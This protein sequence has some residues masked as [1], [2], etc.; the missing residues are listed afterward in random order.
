MFDIK[1]CQW[2]VDL[3]NW[4]RPLYQLM[5][6]PYYVL[7][8]LNVLYATFNESKQ[9]LDLSSILNY[10][11]RKQFWNRARAESKNE[12]KTES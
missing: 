12:L 10:S 7:S 6:L 5:S 11:K 4:K 2:T 1:L 8:L 9:V 3:W